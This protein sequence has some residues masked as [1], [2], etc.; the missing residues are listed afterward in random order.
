MSNRRPRHRRPG[1]TT[2]RPV[3]PSVNVD[4]LDDV[5]VFCRLTQLVDHIKQRAIPAIA[6][7][8]GDEDAAIAHELA[9]EIRR[10]TSALLE[11][12]AGHEPT[13]P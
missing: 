4:E 10:T 8:L 5:C 3:R 11:L 9:D 2:P 13:H 12:F 7:R 6:P 1:R